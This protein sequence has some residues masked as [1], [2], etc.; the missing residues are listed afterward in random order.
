MRPHQN[1]WLQT[2]IFPPSETPEKRGAQYINCLGGKTDLHG[3]GKGEK[4]IFYLRKKTFYRCGCVGEK[5]RP[6]ERAMPVKR[7]A[8][9]REKRVFPHLW[10]HQRKLY[11]HNKSRIVHSSRARTL[12]HLPVLV[13]YPEYIEL[14]YSIKISNT[15][16]G[17]DNNKKA[18]F[19][20][21]RMWNS[22]SVFCYDFI[23]NT[24]ARAP[25]TH[26][27]MKLPRMERKLFL[28]ECYLAQP[29]TRRAHDKENE[30]LLLWRLMI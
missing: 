5:S 2:H 16:E 11:G 30:F 10:L 6:S 29:P 1:V 13:S 20:T 12:F 15:A 24:Y 25:R 22:P 26:T 8:R 18:S 14:W 27:K 4:P 9:E 17:R 23:A 28:P 7:M 19:R 21:R 3:V